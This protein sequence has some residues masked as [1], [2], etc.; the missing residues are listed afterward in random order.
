MSL[1]LV[2]SVTLLGFTPNMNHVS[3]RMRQ[4]CAFLTVVGEGK[5]ENK[6]EKKWKTLEIFSY[7]SKN[8]ILS[9]YWAFFFPPTFDS[10]VFFGHEPS[11]H[12][13]NNSWV[14]ILILL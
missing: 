3:F 4:W 10:F 13:F 14:L 2:P 7:L 8:K 9:Y 1:F 12:H 5:C 11:V 6:G